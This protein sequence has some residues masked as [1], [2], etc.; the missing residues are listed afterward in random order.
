MPTP[1][2]AVAS[3]AVVALGGVGVGSMML[4]S[5]GTSPARRSKVPSLAADP[6]GRPAH[7]R[8]VYTPAAGTDLAARQRADPGAGPRRRRGTRQGAP[9][10]PARPAGGA[11]RTRSR[12][13]APASQAT[14]LDGLPVGWR[15][16]PARPGRRGADASERRTGARRCLLPGL[17]GPLAIARARARCPCTA[18][19]PGLLHVQAN[20]SVPLT[21]E[22]HRL[23]AR[24]QLLGAQ[25]P[26]PRRR[27]ARRR[28]RSRCPGSTPNSRPG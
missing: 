21:A 13:P 6:T 25:R 15:S 22:L 4:H 16:A 5:G 27:P 7:S 17:A 23:H 14:T 11:A 10:R 1:L 8:F 28:S 24:R 2:V 26:R 9:L 3:A 20:G 12:R 19:F 18:P